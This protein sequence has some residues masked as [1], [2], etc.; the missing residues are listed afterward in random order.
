MIGKAV[1]QVLQW[2]LDRLSG[3]Q[4]FQNLICD[5]LELA[6]DHITRAR[7]D[8]EQFLSKKAQLELERRLMEEEEQRQIEYNRALEE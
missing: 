6:Q 7:E 4:N 3:Q 2:M 8:R 5:T 1:N